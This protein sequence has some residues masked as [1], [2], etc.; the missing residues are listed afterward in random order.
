MKLSLYRGWASGLRV[1]LIVLALSSPLLLS[2]C[3]DDDDSDTDEDTTSA[4]LF[5]EN[6]TLQADIRRTTN[7]VPHVKANDLSSAAF[8]TGYAQ[9]QD[10]VCVLADAFIKA[11][12][13]RAKYLGP[14]A[15]PTDP[16]PKNIISDFSYKA[17]KVHSNAKNELEKLSDE[18][19]AMVEGFTAGYNKYVADTDPADLPAE[20][21]DQPW[22]K[23]ISE[24]DLLAYYRIVGKYASGDLFATG[25]LFAAVPPGP[26]TVSVEP[27]APAISEIPTP[28]SLTESA[29]RLASQQ[30]YSGSGLASNAWGI[31]GDLSAQGRGALLANP[32]FPYT[33]DRRLYQVQMTVPDYL[34]INGAGLLG[35]AIPL[36][37]YNENLAWSHTNTSGR[38]FTLYELSLKQ[39]DDLTYIK[40]GEEKPIT[41]ETFQIEVATGEP[42]GPVMREHTFYYSEYGPMLAANAVTGD[43]PLTPTVNEGG[44]PKWGGPN[45]QPQAQGT[46][47]YTYRDANA[48]TGG[49][50]DTWLQMS[51]AHTLDEFQK[52]FHENCGTTLWTNTIYVDDQGNS[53]YIDS[54]SVPNLSAATLANVDFKRRF[55]APYNA[56]FEGGLTLLDGSTSRDD[57]VEGECGT[58]TPYDEK[59]K[60]VRKDFVQNSNGSHWATNPQQFLTGF[61]PL[62]GSE[63]SQLSQ[64]ARLGLSMLQ[65]PLDSGFAEK[66]PAGQ[67]GKF[68]AKDLIDVIYNNRAWYAKQFLGDLLERCKSRPAE[69]SLPQK[70]LPEEPLITS[71]KK[72]SVDKGCEA[73]LA[74][75]GVY[76]KDSQGAH[77]FRVFVDIYT[78]KFPN[79]LTVA[80]DPSDPVNTPA[81]PDQTKVGTENDPMLQSLAASMEIL[82]KV[83]IAYDAKLGEVQYYQPSGD[84]PPGGTPVAQ[85]SRIP[86]HGGEGDVEGTFNAVAVAD[87]N[88]KEDTR[89]PRLNAPEFLD[90]DERGKEVRVAAGLS[91]KRFVANDK[92]N[93]GGWNMAQGTSWHFGLEFTDNGPRAFGLVSYSQSS[94][95]S[96]Q[97]FNDQSERYS[98]KD[99]RTLSFSEKEIQANLLDNGEIT[100]SSD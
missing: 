7:G 48:D 62:F 77:L 97:F 96:S 26:T 76:N 15:S 79:D 49:L 67:D 99:P 98:N 3:G 47:A 78:R 72:R 71:P 95:A 100:I 32:H 57:W 4:P 94:D 19:R 43:D 1:P 82:K 73:I 39:G 21:R 74:W 45:P 86:W 11:R 18:S 33:G 51:R 66:A 22:V 25:A 29:S 46:V 55:S 24:A 34:N 65:N 9:A 88:V 42:S 44:L 61:S 58:L 52:V 31:G 14:G 84:V 38:Q 17:L 53:F 20:C 6:G 60:L 10:N 35:T 2:G 13:E 8:G 87:T 85:S 83:N 90:K 81:K 23:K 40:D 80:F 69:V 28:A 91:T 37:N 12:S 56:L 64:R 5:P 93:E 89:L 63:K 75:D 27:Q 59:P 54:S 41:Q 70:L 16:T 30:D 36:I 68:S 92:N 50:L